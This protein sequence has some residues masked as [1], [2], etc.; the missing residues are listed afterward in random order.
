MMLIDVPLHNYSQHSS[1]TLNWVGTDC[2]DNIERIQSDPTKFKIW[3]DS[4]WSTEALIEY[5]FNEHGFRTDSFDSS[6]RVAVFGSSQTVGVGLHQWQTW[7]NLLSDVLNA[8]IWNLATGTGTFD[9]YYRMIKYFAKELNIEYIIL[10][11]NDDNRWEFWNTDGFPKL[12]NGTDRP[13]GELHAIATAWG[14]HSNNKK[15]NEEKNLEAIKYICHAH[16]L[17]LIIFDTGDANKYKPVE[18]VDWSRCLSHVGP[19][20]HQRIQEYIVDCLLKDMKIP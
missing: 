5:K 11:T 19:R 17:P 14:Q 2:I 4:G 8:P 9:T 1:K 6:R 13:I 16:Q 20:Y 10:M 15:I 18:P 7:P 12:I 3:A